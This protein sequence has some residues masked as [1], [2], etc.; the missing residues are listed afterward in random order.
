MV[1]TWSDSHLLAPQ[2][3]RAWKEKK[4]KKKKKK[5]KSHIWLEINAEFIKQLSVLNISS[6]KD[7]NQVKTEIR[8][9]KK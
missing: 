4:K 5:K 1:L 2:Y 8:S 9:L 6:E 7:F 3:N